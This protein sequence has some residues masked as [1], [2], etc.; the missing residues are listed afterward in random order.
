MTLA[1]A[2]VRELVCAQFRGIHDSARPP[3]ADTL[4]PT[5]A[6]EQS[7][8]A[9]RE[10]ADGKRRQR[11]RTLLR[12]FPA[13]HTHEHSRIDEERER[14]VDADAPVGL[15]GC[16]TD[17]MMRS[18]YCFALGVLAEPT[19]CK[20]SGACR[21]TSHRRFVGGLACMRPIRG[22]LGRGSVS[23]HAR[24]LRRKGGKRRDDSEWR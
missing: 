19:T 23:G 12:L 16:E 14:R 7:S 3:L 4:Q 18:G 15:L 10:P 2:A 9:G 17:R 20:H 6:R 24:S 13:A 11:R 5:E 1:A 21:I 8:T 22:L